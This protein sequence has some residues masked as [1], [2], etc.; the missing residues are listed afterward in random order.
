[1]EEAAAKSS[2]SDNEEYKDIRETIAGSP[3]RQAAAA[4]AARGRQSAGRPA[5]KTKGYRPQS[6]AQA[7]AH[8]RFVRAQ[9][10][11]NIR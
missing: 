9:R 6:T 7:V 2:E 3:G 4:R 10:A 1:M 5:S 8:A 11:A